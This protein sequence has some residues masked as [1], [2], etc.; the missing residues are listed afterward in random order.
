MNTVQTQKHCKGEM[1]QIHETQQNLANRGTKVRD[2][3]IL[4][5]QSPFKL[6]AE[7][8]FSALVEVEEV[9]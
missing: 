2:G 8:I 3:P 9:G 7:C 1:L 5:D 4:W 6:R